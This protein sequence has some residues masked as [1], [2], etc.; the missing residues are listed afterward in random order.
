[1]ASVGFRNIEKAYG[2]VKVIHGHRV[3]RPMVK[4]KRHNIAFRN[5]CDD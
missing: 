3:M 5:S 1:M 4:L 2:S